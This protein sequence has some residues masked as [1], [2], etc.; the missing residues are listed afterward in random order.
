LKGNT[1]YNPRLHPD[2][3]L[4]RR[5]LV[6]ELM[7]EQAKLP[8]ETYNHLVELPLALDYSNL[9]YEGPAQYFLFQVE[10]RARE[11]LSE[12]ENKT[13]TQYNIESDG[14]IITTTLDS[15]LQN[16]TLKAVRKQLP[17]M[18][19]LFNIDPEVKNKKNK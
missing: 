4:E 2:R 13:N 6:L 7:N 10:K 1:Y 15:K 5:N 14:L 19:K 16:M 3:A 9:S 8:D 17:S 11:I 12:I 18:Q